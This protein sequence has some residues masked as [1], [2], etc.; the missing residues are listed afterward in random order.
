[1]TINDHGYAYVVKWG[2]SL[3]SAAGYIQVQCDLALEDG[4]PPDATYKG[5]DGAWRTTAG[6]ISSVTRRRL[7]LDPLPV[8]APAIMAAYDA[9]VTFTGDDGTAFV[10]FTS[11]ARAIEWAVHY[12]VSDRASVAVLGKNRALTG[13]A[14]LMLAGEATS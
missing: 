1:M 14:T 11:L 4:A 10:E 9:S 12:K 13:P 2:A 8:T 5:Q 6:V 7:G 3:G